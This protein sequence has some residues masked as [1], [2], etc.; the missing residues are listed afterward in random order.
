[1][2]PVRSGN[3]RTPHGT[4][5]APSLD[6]RWDVESLLIALEARALCCEVEAQIVSG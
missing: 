5:Q 1:M 6:L 4:D 2:G 3:P